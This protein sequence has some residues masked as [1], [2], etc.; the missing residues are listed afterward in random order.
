[1]IEKLKYIILFLNVS[2]VLTNIIM[3]PNDYITIQNA[4]RKRILFCFGTMMIMG[5]I[6]GHVLIPSS[7][8]IYLMWILN[9]FYG[10]CF[11]NHIKINNEK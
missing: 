3:V 5:T 4:I 7:H 8:F 9:L 6:L 2:F 10:F 1:M 11:Y